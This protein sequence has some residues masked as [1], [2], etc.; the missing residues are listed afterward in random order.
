ML[1]RKL[2]DTLLAW[3]NRKD[4]HMCLIVKGARQVGK[5][6]IIKDFAEKHYKSTIY[7]N[8]EET[9]SL[10]EIFS[11]DL[12][13]E[14]L[15]K[16]I[17]L[18]IG[19][20]VLIEGDTLIFLDEIQSCPVARTAL[21][22]FAIDG[23]YDVVASGSLLGI[24]YKEVPS[25]PTGY[26]EAVEMHSLD[27]EEFLW[28]YGVNAEAVASLQAYF[29]SGKPLPEA[30]HKRMISI[31]REYIVVGG[32]PA[33][34]NDFMKS[35]DF[36][37]VLRAQR[38]IIESYKNDIAKYAPYAEKVKAHDCFA[39]IPRQLAKEYKKFRYALVDKKG[40]ARKYEGSLMWLYDAG[41]INFCNNL[42]TAELPLEGNVKDGCFKIYMRDI[43][44]L[45]AMLEDGSQRDIMTGNLGIYK[46]AIYENLIADIFTKI[47]KKLYYFEETSR[48]EVDFLIRNKGALTAVEVKATRG[49]ANSLERVMSFTPALKGIKLTS[50]NVGESNGI[51]T[52]PLY[53]AMFL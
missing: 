34:V 39:S 10:K 31:L 35:H 7:I 15:R 19:S 40:T 38:A 44:L 41:I 23:R 24:N 43:G 5:T 17:T 21:K 37:A 12:D 18:Y 16:Q 2:S 14:T 36:N 50:G 9:P 11:G 6:F 28:A 46:G 48:F 30:M 26:E 53:M 22:F 27:L 33:V 20:A 13:I 32:R 49:A 29:D 51:K 42:T 3:K 52:Y 8:F 47:G 25:Y 45:T 4:K 1:R